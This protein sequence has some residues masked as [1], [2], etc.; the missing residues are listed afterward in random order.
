[1]PLQ[2]IRRIIT[3]MCLWT[4]KFDLRIKLAIFSD[5]THTAANGSEMKKKHF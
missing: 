5:P 3:Q 4:G 2:T 1:M